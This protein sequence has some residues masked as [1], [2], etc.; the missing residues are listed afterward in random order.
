MIDLL[1]IT[2]I[3]EYLIV[4]KRFQVHSHE[5]TVSNKDTANQDS[6]V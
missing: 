1:T 5:K 4:I 6:H 2:W 3:D